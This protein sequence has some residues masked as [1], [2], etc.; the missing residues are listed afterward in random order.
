MKYF[1]AAIALLSS[2]SA[3][4]QD[5][6]EGDTK[7]GGLRVEAHVGI[8]R[9]NLSDNSNGKT[10][11]A[12]LSSSLAY[13]AE[14]GYDIPVSESVTV[15]PYLSYD[16]ANSDI[17]DSGSFGINLTAQVCFKA[18][19][20]L[21]VGVRGAVT[22]GKSEVYLG[23]GYD[24]YNYEWTEVVKNTSSQAIISSYSNLKGDNGI[25]VSFG[26]NQ[27]ISKK[28]YVGLG[29]RISEMGKFE[30]SGAKLQRFQGQLN[31][32]ARF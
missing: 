4:A 20:N 16:L 19:S 23:L 8:E 10:Y 14:V 28:M 6:S 29:V 27:N 26:Y 31:L 22:M 21:S 30:G 32:G 9:P 7:N 11:V 12:K 2:N 5:N 18:K 13:G 3:F 1:I 17:C 15:G 25:G 24:K